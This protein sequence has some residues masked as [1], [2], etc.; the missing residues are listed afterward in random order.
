MPEIEKHYVDTFNNTVDLLAQQEKSILEPLVLTQPCKGKTC[1]VKDFTGQ[2]EAREKTER[3]EKT[4]YSETPRYRRWLAPRTF[5]TAEKFDGDDVIR[6]LTD[7]ESSLAKGHVAAMNRCKDG[8]IISQFFAAARTGELPTSGTTAYDTNMDVAADF[9]LTGT[10]SG[11]SPF[12]LIK[13]KSLYIAQQVDP[14]RNKP[15]AIMNSKAYL[16]LHL[17]GST[18]YTSGDYN[19]KKPLQ[20]ASSMIDFGGHNLVSLD[21]I[22][23]PKNG[24]TEWYL[25]SWQKDGMVLGIWAGRKVTVKPVPDEVDSFEIKIV[26]KYAACRVDEKKVGRVKI[27][28][29]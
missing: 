11:L 26:E 25:P 4:K 6:M 5:Y 7:P 21:H 12:K 8:V 17:P 1:A 28:F 10:P 19:N 16:D 18:S 15:F 20:E 27:K 29:A 13:M 22:Q 2:I 24:A 14:D 3:F 9:D 23:Q